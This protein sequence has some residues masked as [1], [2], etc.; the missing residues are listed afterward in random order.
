MRAYFQKKVEQHSKWQQQTDQNNGGNKN[1]SKAFGNN[2]TE[3][4]NN[5]IH[6]HVQKPTFFF[7]C[8]LC[9][10]RAHM[11]NLTPS[12][13]STSSLLPLQSQI[14]SWASLKSPRIR[15]SNKTFNWKFNHHTEDLAFL[16]NNNGPRNC[17]PNKNGSIGLF[18]QVT[19]KERDSPNCS[20]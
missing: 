1:S 19:E 16:S 8:L 18:E 5:R 12:H 2:I 10:C 11:A 6:F 17:S 13:P 3:V 4:S 7:F 15:R 14:F 20:D 9:V